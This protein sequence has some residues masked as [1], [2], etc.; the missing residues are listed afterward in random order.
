MLKLP[1]RN[2]LL[3][4][5]IAALGALSAP[6]SAA[7]HGAAVESWD[8]SF[9]GPF[10]TYDR[11]ELQRGYQV[12]KEVCSA[13]HSLNRIAFRNLSDA[14]GPGFTELEV[15]A[16]AAS[17]QIPA[18]PNERGET[19]DAE[20][21]PLMRE[22]LPSDYFPSRFP[23]DNAARASNN[24]ALPP[25]LSL[26]TKARDGGSDYIYA[27]LTGYGH[28][29]PAGV[30]VNPGQYYNPYFLGG[31]LAM[32]QPLFANQVTYADGTEASIEQMAHD[33]TAFLTWTAEPKME[34]R[35]SLGFAVI[36][37]LMAFSGLCFLSYRKLWHGEH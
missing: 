18:E 3:A 7:E 16:L 26:I 17:Y 14:G 32:P 1:M 4:F 6:A 27:L 22:A 19:T 37:F 28:E 15:R 29:V 36:L 23:N 25:D 21:R 2:A 34:E 10:G 20:G 13:C 33:V 30:T 9:N 31:L 35:K 8:W 12:Y 5:G 11:A 24:G